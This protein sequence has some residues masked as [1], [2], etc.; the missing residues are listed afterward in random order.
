MIINPFIFPAP[1]G[2][3]WWEAGGATGCV[4]AYQPKGA[5]SYAASKSN[6]VSPG[7][8]DATEPTAHV[9]TWNA[10]TG[11]SFDGAFATN[12][13]LSTGYMPSDGNI[14]MIA[15]YTGATGPAFSIFSGSINSGAYFYF[16]AFSTTDGFSN[17]PV[18]DGVAVSVPR[19]SGNFAI[20]GLDGYANG[21]N[22]G[23]DP[24]PVCSYISPIFVG[25]AATFPGNP[26]GR[27]AQFTCIAFA[28]Y[29]GV[30]NATEVSAVAA[31]MAAL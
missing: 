28:L 13:V 19:P 29:S 15:Q 26:A 9:P 18:T 23:T 21:S 24:G 10:S 3:N 7:T 27:G 4:R 25:D 30:L 12:Q 2:G 5:A 8:G 16:G 17:G 6:L 20:A 14:S 11:W 1:G 22:A 31:A